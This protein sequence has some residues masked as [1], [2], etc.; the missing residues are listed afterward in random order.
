[1]SRFSQTLERMRL[2]R[3]QLSPHNPHCSSV[4][5]G[6]DFLGLSFA[7]GRG[8]AILGPCSSDSFLWISVERR[9]QTSIAVGTARSCG[10]KV[11]LVVVGLLEQDGSGIPLEDWRVTLLHQWDG[12][13]ALMNE[14]LWVHENGRYIYLCVCVCVCVRAYCLWSWISCLFITNVNREHVWANGHKV[15]DMNFLWLHPVP[16]TGNESRQ[17]WAR[18]YFNW[19]SVGTVIHETWGLS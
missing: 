19:T 10:R 6:P 14:L 18:K 2:L 9:Q 3:L 17:S 5:I 11:W 4:K 13:K 16:I 7:E 15:D 12:L 8:L 1:M